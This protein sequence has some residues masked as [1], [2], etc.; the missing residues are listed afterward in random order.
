MSTGCVSSDVFEFIMVLLIL[1]FY[2]VGYDEMFFFY[3]SN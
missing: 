1:N 2:M 3:N